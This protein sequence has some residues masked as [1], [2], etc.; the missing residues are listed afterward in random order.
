MASI[1]KVFA[2]VSSKS[3]KVQKC[4]EPLVD[5]F[6][7]YLKIKTFL[8]I[9]SLLKNTQHS[10]IGPSKCRPSLNMKTPLNISSRL[11]AFP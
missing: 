4:V 7:N 9:S 1:S 3:Y 8:Q 10:R 5:T 11:L 6:Y 2:C